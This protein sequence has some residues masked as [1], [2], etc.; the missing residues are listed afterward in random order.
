MRRNIL[1]KNDFIDV[2]RVL[3]YVSI[4]YIVG[5]EHDVLR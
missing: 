3:L 5:L 1:K 2:T 4:I